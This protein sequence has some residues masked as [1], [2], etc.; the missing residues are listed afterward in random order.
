MLIFFGD[1]FIFIMKGIF[2]LLKFFKIFLCLV[3]LGAY[4]YPTGT[5]FGVGFSATTGLNAFTGY[6]NKNAESFWGKRLGYRIDFA[7]TK[8]VR[9]GI[10]SAINHLVDDRNIKIGDS[11]LVNGAEIEAKH[12]GGMLDFYPFGNTWFLGGWRLSGGYYG[13]KFDATAHVVGGDE[14][15][16]FGLGHN[17]YR[18]ADGAFHAR[19]MADWK[20]DGPYVGTGFDL[21]LVAG[22]KIYFDAGVVF[23]RKVAKIGLDVP[24]GDLFKWDGANWALVDPDELEQDKQD[25]LRDAQREAD[26]VKYFPIV[27]LGLM[28]R[29]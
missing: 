25:V 22:F 15:G 3:P 28:Y 18:Y 2:S 5:Q 8:I 11:I 9:S 10:N 13:G 14:N 27:K 12:F 23:T 7:G 17:R 20:Y 4:A 16:E 19:A 1:Y 24:D 21:C 26:K 6:V 29:F